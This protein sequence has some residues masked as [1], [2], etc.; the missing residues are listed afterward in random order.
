MPD[1]HLF[2]KRVK[3]RFEHLPIICAICISTWAQAAAGISSEQHSFTQTKISPRACHI[4][5]EWWGR[6]AGHYNHDIKR[7]AAEVSWRALT[8]QASF[9]LQLLVACWHRWTR[10]LGSL[11]AAAQDLP[12]EWEQYWPWRPSDRGYEGE[13]RLCLLAPLQVCSLCWFMRL[14][15]T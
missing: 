8:K 13:R 15:W 14:R 4:V 10:A 5:C 9:V 2:E 1:R 12:A 3:T 7:L 11:P 6:K